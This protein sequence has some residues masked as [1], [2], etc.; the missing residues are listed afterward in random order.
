MEILDDDLKNE[1]AQESIIDSFVPTK[2][3]NDTKLEH[4]VVEIEEMPNVIETYVEM[5]KNIKI[6]NLNLILK[7][8]KD[9]IIIDPKITLNIINKSLGL[10]NKTLVDFFYNFYFY[11]QDEILNKTF[12]NKYIYIRV[13]ILIFNQTGENRIQFDY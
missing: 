11:N 12:K 13:P 1:I 5:L 10:N 7:A 6:Q 8:T 4:R 2:L 9:T 3:K